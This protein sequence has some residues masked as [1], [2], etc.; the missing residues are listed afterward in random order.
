M[1][2]SKSAVVLRGKK[3]KVLFVLINNS[4]SLF[5]F[6]PQAPARA[7]NILGPVIVLSKG[8]EKIISQKG[9]VF[10]RKLKMDVAGLFPFA[11]FVAFFLFF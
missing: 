3:L 5:A 7:M 11:H 6:P 9:Q 10:D 8:I 2:L 4:S 1:G